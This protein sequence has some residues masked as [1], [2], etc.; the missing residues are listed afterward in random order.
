MSLASR[1]GVQQFE[2][3][4][5]GHNAMAF[6]RTLLL[7]LV[8]VLFQGSI[9]SAAYP[10]RVGKA[11]PK[12]ALW[13]L[14][15]EQTHSLAAHVGKK[16]LI[17]HFATWSSAAS[18]ELLA[19][20]EATKKFVADGKLVL[21]PVSHD[22]YADRAQL[23]AQWKKVET[24]ILFDPIN[25]LGLETVPLVVAVDEFGIVRAVNPKPDTIGEVF[26]N[27]K[28]KGK[29][30]KLAEGVTEPPDAR[31]TRRVAGE[32]RD[33]EEICAH[34]VALLIAGEPPLL[35]E[36]V[37]NY[38]EALK[39]KPRSAEASFG[40][41]VACRKR[42]D[43]ESRQPG[44]LTAAISAWTRA[45]TLEPR[46]GLYRARLAEFLPLRSGQK[47]PYDWVATAEKG[48]TAA[49]KTPILLSSQPVKWDLPAAK[50][51]EAS[52][53][54]EVDNDKLVSIDCVL[55]PSRDKKNV[56]AGLHVAL[57]PDTQRQVQWH[58]EAEKTSIHLLKSDLLKANQP[59]LSIANPKQHAS[60]ET[61]IISFPITFN[62]KEAAAG[63][64]KAVA[65]Y[66]LTEPGSA[67]PKRLRQEFEIEI[68]R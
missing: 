15:H 41:G 46:N 66:T 6:T 27:K 3:N 35:E 26:V 56:N 40:L 12:L 25:S 21:L 36:A 50:S 53:E 29:P 17:L 47:G 2:S 61:R 65:Y 59:A 58:N 63:T 14:A 67:G 20:Q 38:F 18:K 48:I 52:D 49:G 62:S 16:V 57:W 33:V 31:I 30:P 34:C 44:D 42:L 64:V 55:V 4:I 1:L 51:E 11:H 32:G 19:W 7:S 37:N 5:A 22:Q 45:T 23:F 24:P 39:K 8:L 68:K 28:F 13:D 54:A 9:G 43:C 10:P 60:N